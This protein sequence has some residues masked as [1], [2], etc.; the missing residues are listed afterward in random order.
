MRLEK[1]EIEDRLTK[2][3]GWRYSNGSIIKDYRLGDFREA[4]GFVV[5][6]ALAAEKMEHHPDLTIEYDRVKVIL[7]THAENGVTEKDFNLAET[8]ENLNRA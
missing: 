1:Q 7:T 6:I 8:I 5:K 2:I 4:M 3:S